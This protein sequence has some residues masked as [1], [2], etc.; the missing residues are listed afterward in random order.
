MILSLPPLRGSK[1]VI[2]G[3]AEL[4]KSG[5]KKMC[6]FQRALKVTSHPSPFLPST[7]FSLKNL[8]SKV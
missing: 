6:D 4:A 2:L 7:C 1:S 3:D 8:N 5:Q